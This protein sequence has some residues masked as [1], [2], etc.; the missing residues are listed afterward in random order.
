MD[1]QAMAD[2]MQAAVREMQELQLAALT[3]DP[4]LRRACRLYFRKRGGG[5]RLNTQER[6]RSFTKSTGDITSSC[7]TIAAR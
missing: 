4:L 7:A 5:G 2:A 6:S 1:T 3:D